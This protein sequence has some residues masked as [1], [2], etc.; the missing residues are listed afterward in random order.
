MQKNFIKKMSLNAT[1]ALTTKTTTSQT[2]SNI[3]TALSL[4][5]H[6]DNS[7]IIISISEEQVMCNIS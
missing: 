2:N 3:L 5:V 1:V 7:A 6:I 4:F